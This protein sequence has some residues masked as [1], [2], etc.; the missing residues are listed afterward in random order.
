MIRIDADLAPRVAAEPGD[1]H[2]PR[3]AAMRGLRRIGGEKRTVIADAVLPRQRAE[4]ARTCHQ[5]CHQIRHRRARDEDAARAFREGEQAAHPVD[6]LA[7]AL[8]RHMVAAAEIGVEACREHFR[9]HADRGAAAVHP[10]HE[11]GMDVPGRIGRDMFGEVA[12]D[13]GE[14]TRL[15]WH[16]GLECRTNAVGD[17]LPHRMRAYVGDAVDRLVQ[18][19]MGERAK[20][21]PV[22]RIERSVRCGALR[23]A[24]D[25]VHAALSS[26]AL[27]CRDSIAVNAAKILR[28][29]G[30]LYGNT[31]G[32]SR[33]CTTAVLSASKTSSSRFWFSAQS[34]MK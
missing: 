29:C 23:V 9:D 19:A 2:R 27:A 13:V 17:R 5:Y 18:H 10:A 15:A 25:L 20:L 8:D 28:I 7:L 24:D 1:V 31:A 30:G 34:T 11:T 21:A 12:I 33:L 14:I 6:D 26:P 22:L 4:R 16:V 3:D 32:G